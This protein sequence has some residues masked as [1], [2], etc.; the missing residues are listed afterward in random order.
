M[1]CLCCFESLF[2]KSGFDYSKGFPAG[3]WRKK[4]VILTAMRR[5]D[6]TS[7]QYGVILAPSAHSQQ[8]M[9]PNAVELTSMRRNDVASTSVRCHM[10]AWLGPFPVDFVV[11]LLFYAHGKHLRSCRDSHA[12]TFA[13]NWQ[14]PFLKKRKE[15]RKYVA[16]PGIEPWTPDLRVRCPT[17]CA[18]RPGIPR[19]TTW[20]R[21][22]ILNINTLLWII[23]IS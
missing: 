4:Y 9:T 14:R 1:I 21:R 20:I 6:V 5:D 13:S 2:N 16:R 3:T 17:D 23:S 18:T 12:H 10:L 7:T 15:K 22:M 19:G 8:N 11:A